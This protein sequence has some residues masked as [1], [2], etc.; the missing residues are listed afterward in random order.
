[1]LMLR[2]IPVMMVVLSALATTALAADK[3]DRTDLADSG[4]QAPGDYGARRPQSDGPAA[5]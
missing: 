1:M 5:L 2:L 3:L 4:T